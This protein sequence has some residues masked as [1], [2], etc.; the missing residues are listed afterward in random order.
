MVKPYFPHDPAD[1]LKALNA[2]RVK[3]LVVGGVAVIFHG[4]LRTTLDLDLAV[5]LEVG[6]LKKLEEVMHRLGFSPRVPAS[7]T[8]LADS[9]TRRVWTRQKHMKVFSFTE[10][11]KPF[12]IVD[13][14]VRPLPDFERLYRTRVTVK[15]GGVSAPVMPLSALM[16]MKLA[17]GRVQDREDVQYLHI[18]QQKMRRRATA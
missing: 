13:V 5:H 14:M 8:G 2:S 18:V 15:H 1:I 6:N 4:V 10:H 17:A 11:R 9:R 16:K 3:Y 12:R 7:V